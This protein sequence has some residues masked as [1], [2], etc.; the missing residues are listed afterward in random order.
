MLGVLLSGPFLIPWRDTVKLCKCKFVFFRKWGDIFIYTV[1]V[2]W[3]MDI[4]YILSL[5]CVCVYFSTRE[6][7]IIKI[8]YL[9]APHLIALPVLFVFDGVSFCTLLHM[10]NCLSCETLSLLAV[11]L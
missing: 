6:S 10:H 1:T 9:I 3:I 8:F 5:F 7:L 11:E 2:I 4:L